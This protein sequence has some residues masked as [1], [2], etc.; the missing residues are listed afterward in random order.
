[1][2]LLPGLSLANQVAR[3]RL[4]ANEPNGAL[5][6]R[7]STDH[8]VGFELSYEVDFWGRNR[9][10]ASAARAEAF[11]A[12]SDFSVGLLTLTADVARDYHQLRALDAEKRV[13]EATLELRQDALVLQTS[14][15]GA[16]LINDADVSRARTELANVEAEL[17]AITRQRSRLEHALAVL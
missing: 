3:Q 2:D 15:H 14:R 7:T 9:Q 6:D 13:V 8:R 11:A 1:A 16:G 12:E 5:G 17:H 4:S 10:A